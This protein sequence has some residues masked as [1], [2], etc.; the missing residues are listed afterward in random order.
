MRYW[1]EFCHDFQDK[2]V[3]VFGLGLQGGGVKVANTLQAAGAQV[4]VSDAKSA[5]ALAPS[6]AQLHP[7]IEVHVGEQPAEDIAWAE[8][9][10]KNP[11][12]PY[13]HP[14]MQQALGKNIPVLGETALAIK[15]LRNHCI[16]VTGTRGKTT[17]SHL[18]FHFL[19]AGHI[20]AVLAGNI[21]GKP[22]LAELPTLD[23]NTW[24]VVEIPSFQIES[25]RYTKT[26]AHIA[27]ITTL[28][29]DHLNRYPNWEAY[30]RAK[31]DLLKYQQP[32]DVAVYQADRNWTKDIETAL[33]QGTE[34]RPVSTKD[35]NQLQQRFTSLLPGE[36]NWENIALA[37]AVSQEFSLSDQ[38]IQSVLNTFTGV[39]YRL[40][41]IATK[42]GITYVNDTTS[43]TPVALEK[44]LDTYQNRQFIL[45][46][47]GG[48]KDLPFSPELAQKMAQWPLATVLL[49]G[50][51]EQLVQRTWQEQGIQP[52]RVETADSLA[53][54]VQQARQLAQELSADVVLLSPGFL[55]FEMFNNEF[56]R[57][58]QFNALV[59]QLPD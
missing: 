48:L 51:G 11:G 27:V 8:Y 46:A 20:P 35:R 23:E 59:Q 5:E 54:A 10:I 12:V 39:P 3:L 9:V 57:G 40:E 28:Y 45:I 41:T 53:S 56:D 15:Y 21:P 43:T 13:E 2:K 4:R 22:L 32:G 58:D 34:S 44:A 49:R 55:S 6:L 33:A 1:S 38:V 7:E 36:H 42:Q 24:A 17:T 18:I 50:Q 26:S 25:F 30:V 29:P 31:T 19:Q 16:A 37:Y 47:G 52:S 14:L